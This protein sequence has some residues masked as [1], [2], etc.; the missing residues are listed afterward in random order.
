MNDQTAVKYF[1]TIPHKIKAGGNIYVFAV[2]AN[3]CLCWI[4]NCD[5]DKVLNMTKSCCGGRT[6]KVYRLANESDIRR[7]TNK[8]GS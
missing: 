1:Q 6:N 4:N 2:A 3:I 5:V 7:W 8:G